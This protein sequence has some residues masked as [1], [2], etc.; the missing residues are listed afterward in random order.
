MKK[1]LTCRSL[2]LPSVAPSEI[3]S[4]SSPFEAMKLALRISMARGFFSPCLEAH[5]CS[6][7][8]NTDDHKT[9]L[10]PQPPR[11]AGISRSENGN[12]LP[13]F[14]TRRHC[15]SRP[16]FPFTKLSSKAAAYFPPLF[17]LGSS[18]L[19]KTISQISR[20]K[21]EIGV[22][23]AKKGTDPFR[24]AHPEDSFQTLLP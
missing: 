5:M 17:L 7:F 23:K 3:R 24:S 6:G 21:S 15:W 19:W 1:N 2:S 4:P 14:M 9:F 18:P 12:L 10:V 13:F 11:K 16:A 22:R 8:A 20:K